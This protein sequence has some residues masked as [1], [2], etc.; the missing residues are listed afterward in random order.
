[1]VMD[2]AMGCNFNAAHKPFDIEEGGTC[3]MHVH[4]PCISERKNII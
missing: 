2:R 3:R 1:M 4:V